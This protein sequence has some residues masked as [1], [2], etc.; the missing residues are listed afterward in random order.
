MQQ[1]IQKLNSNNIK[2]YLAKDKQAAKDLALEL[3]PPNAIIAMGNSLS[4]RETGIFEALTTGSYQLI[5][6]FEPGISPGENLKRRKQG[7][8]AD[9]YFTG[10]NALTTAGELINIDG[11]GNRVAAMMFGPEKVIVVVGKNKLV[12]NEAAAWQ[13]L[14]DLVA[15][16]LAKKLGRSTPCA[17]T[18]KCA[19]CKS[20]ERICRLYTVIKSQ[21]PA[22]AERIN[23]IIVN[24]NL[25]I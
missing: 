5:N 12:E 10:T 18:G 20:P 15:P 4:L 17:Q 2:A 14:R 9:V 1:L 6:Q 11:K 22:D 21:M 8:L 24:E 7:L 13:R 23:V 16:S 19:D 3:I 25:G